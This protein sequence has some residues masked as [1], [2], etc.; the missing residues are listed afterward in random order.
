MQP[1]PTLGIALV[2][3]T[4]VE[5]KLKEKKKAFSMMKK[6]FKWVWSNGDGS[7]WPFSHPGPL[8]PFKSVPYSVQCYLSP[9]F[10][11]GDKIF[12]HNLA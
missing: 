2:D 6:L 8:P 4:S 5:H 7:D 1:Q 9:E 12:F 10:S 11:M 3:S